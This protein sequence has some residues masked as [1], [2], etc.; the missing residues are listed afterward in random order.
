MFDR[1]WIQDPLPR[2]HLKIRFDGSVPH[3]MQWY[4]T[5]ALGSHHGIFATPTQMVASY[6]LTVRNGKLRFT[7]PG[8]QA[9]SSDMAV[10]LSCGFCLHL[11]TSTGFQPSTFPH[12][13]SGLHVAK[14]ISSP[15]A[16]RPR[17]SGYHVVLIL[18][19]SGCTLTVAVASNAQDL[20]RTFVLG[21][22]RLHVLDPSIV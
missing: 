11:C 10:L 17:Q 22:R 9:V 5:G 1:M 16:R 21:S 2:V 6:K 14:L 18:N 20:G 4:T 19:C 8:R 13:W 15:V 3:I 7:S 12:S